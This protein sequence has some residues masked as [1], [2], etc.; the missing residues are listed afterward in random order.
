MS[1]FCLF[2]LRSVRLVANIFCTQAIIYIT[3]NQL[4]LTENL[5]SYGFGCP[6]FRLRFHA[7]TKFSTHLFIDKL[8]LDKTFL[9]WRTHISCL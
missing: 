6:E 9:L 5:I 3:C 8:A 7:L 1:S 2:M 4:H